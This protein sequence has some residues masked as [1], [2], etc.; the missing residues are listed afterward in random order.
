MTMQHRVTTVI[1]MG[2]ALMAATS[3][4]SRE[5]QPSG[6]AEISCGGH[7]ENLATY[8]EMSQVLFNDRQAE[9]VGEFYAEDFVSHNVDEGGTGARI[10]KLVDM[11]NMWR[12]IEQ[13]EPDREVINNVIICNGDL[14]VAQV[15]TQGTHVG[16]GLV[17]N[18][19]GGRRYKTSAMDIYRF[20]DG[21][22]IER[23]GNNDLV[24]KARQLGQTLDLSF[25]PLKSE[26]MTGHS[27]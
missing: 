22:V 2:L 8:L 20:K 13:I 24:A 9:R 4:A 25:K 5:T 10:V 14:V 6:G 16:E 27:H 23:W 15:T 7:S 19:E 3:S 12:S 18:P 17:G 26:D 1:G 11:Q 21:K